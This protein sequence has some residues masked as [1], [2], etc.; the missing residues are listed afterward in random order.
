MLPAQTLFG[1]DQIGVQPARRVRSK[2]GPGMVDCQAAAGW[3]LL[4]RTPQMLRFKWDNG[5]QALRGAMYDRSLYR[6]FGKM[7]FEAP[8]EGLY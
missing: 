8:N 5:G 6:A 2:P 7:S 4:R 3:H 1:E